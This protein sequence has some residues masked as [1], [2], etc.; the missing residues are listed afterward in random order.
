MKTVNFK[1]LG[2]FFLLSLSLPFQSTFGGDL[3]RPD[4]PGGS[5]TSSIVNGSLDYTNSM[6]E[7]ATPITYDILGNNLAVSFNSC[8]GKATI[9]IEDQYGNT[10]YQSVVNTNTQSVLYIPVQGLETGNYTLSVTSASTNFIG[11][12]QL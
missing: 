7:L 8:I 11:V 9:S 2:T 3:L 5:T 10:I 12:F 1:F 6:M 4:D